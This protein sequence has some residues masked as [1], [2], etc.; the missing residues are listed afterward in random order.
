MVLTAQENLG[1]L[2]TAALA[3]LAVQCCGWPRAKTS[4]ASSA[5]RRPSD[6]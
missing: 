5:D 6:L 2:D 4:G 3:T 1:D